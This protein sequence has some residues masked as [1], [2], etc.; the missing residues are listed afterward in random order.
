[1]QTPRAD[2]TPGRQQSSSLISGA[3]ELVVQADLHG[4]DMLAT[5]RKRIGAIPRNRR[6]IAEI[7]ITEVDKC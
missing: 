7:I 2:L 3:D 4:L 6:P 1:M 5:R